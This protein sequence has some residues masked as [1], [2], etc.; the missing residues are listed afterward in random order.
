MLRTDLRNR[1]QEVT[2]EGLVL[3]SQEFSEQNHLDINEKMIELFIEVKKNFNCK[4]K[5][6]K[7][8]SKFK[9]S[10]QEHRILSHEEN[11]S[12]MDHN[13][14]QGKMEIDDQILSRK[15]EEAEGNQEPEIEDTLDDNILYL[16]EKKLKNFKC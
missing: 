14:S 1:L 5:V 9:V 6:I 2:L 13:S 3:I 4:K 16:V 11:Q 7:N 15:N 12:N 10:N 8:P